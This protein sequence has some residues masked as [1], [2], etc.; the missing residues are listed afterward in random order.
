MHRREH[1]VQLL[2]ALLVRGLLRDRNEA[3]T[4]VGV[5][6]LS[7]SVKDLAGGEVAR[8]LTFYLLILLHFK[9]RL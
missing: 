8:L 4:L 7:V 9:N 6:L 2:L 3:A 1:V 5:V